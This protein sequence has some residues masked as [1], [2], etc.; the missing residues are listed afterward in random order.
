MPSGQ[1]AAASGTACANARRSLPEVVHPAEHGFIGDRNPALGE[2]L[3]VVDEGSAN[4][5][6]NS[7]LDDRRVRTRHFGPTSTLAVACIVF[8]PFQILAE[9]EKDGSS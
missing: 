1:S 7:G 5:K 3:D 8:P 6:M 9:Y 4:M 2:L